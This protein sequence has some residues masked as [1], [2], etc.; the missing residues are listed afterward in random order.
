M[1]VELHVILDEF[2]PAS[3]VI[4]HAHKYILPTNLIVQDDKR[5]GNETDG[6]FIKNKFIYLLQ[7][8]HPVTYLTIAMFF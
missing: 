7:D 2:A 5:K 6:N 1:R 4:R 3:S 8:L